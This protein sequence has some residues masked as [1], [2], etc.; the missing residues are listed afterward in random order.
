MP[1]HLVRTCIAGSIA[2]SA[3]VASA[4]VSSQSSIDVSG[5]N[6]MIN[7]NCGNG[8]ARVSG[9]RNRVAL[10]GPCA[11]LDLNGSDNEVAVEMA[12]N[13]SIRVLGD[14]NTIMWRAPGEI[15]VEQLGR[16]NEVRRAP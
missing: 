10:R 12:A 7:A 1:R 13:G 16:N 5:N 2:A 3:A 9:N 15:R 4:Q 14:G 11:T 6:Q 8:T